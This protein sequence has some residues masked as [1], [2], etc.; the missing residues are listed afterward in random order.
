M[1]GRSILFALGRACTLFRTIK[2]VGLNL[3]SSRCTL[4][5][6]RKDREHT[7]DRLTRGTGSLRADP[8]CPIQSHPTP[9]C[10]QRQ[11]SHRHVREQEGS[12]ANRAYVRFTEAREKGAMAPVEWQGCMMFYTTVA[13]LLA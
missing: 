3:D 1:A 9:P 6:S 2:D 5:I 10:S 11:V 8:T 13:S 4:Y 12:A 7:A